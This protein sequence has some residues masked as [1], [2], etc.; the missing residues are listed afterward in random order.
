MSVKIPN[1]SILMP[2]NSTE[3]LSETL[4]SI[5]L[6]N[7]D[8]NALELILVIDRVPKEDVFTLAKKIPS[9]P[10]Y[11]II[12]SEV[13]GIVPALNKGMQSCRYEF[14]ARI[15][16]D[17]MMTKNRIID[18]VEFLTKSGYSAVGGQLRLI[19]EQGQH[20]GFGYFPI[21]Q[22]EIEYSKLLNSPLAHPAVL[23]RKLDVINVGAYREAYPEDWDLWLRLMKNGKIGNVKSIVLDYR[24]HGSQLSR[25]IGYELSSARSRMRQLHSNF[26]LDKPISILDVV[27]KKLAPVFLQLKTKLWTHHTRSARFVLKIFHR[28]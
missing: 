4:K 24:V 6:I 16:S 3:F 19:N 20:I 17:D 7:Y 8:K 9:L 21:T 27:G 1:V 12:E 23:F 11:T 10:S 22:R 25:S 26:D 28:E 15:D 2:I 13:P 14:I 5:S 18:Q